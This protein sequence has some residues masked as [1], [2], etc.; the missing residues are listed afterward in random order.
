MQEIKLIITQDVEARHLDYEV[1][2]NI[3]YGHTIISIVPIKFE[4]YDGVHSDTYL[5]S[6]YKIVMLDCRFN[7]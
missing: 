2:A 5:V 6:K 1:E 4:V 3:K 7:R